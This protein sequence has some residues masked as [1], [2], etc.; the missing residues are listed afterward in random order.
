[1]DATTYINQNLDVEKLLRYYDFQHIT[2]HNDLIRAC[3][4]LH[5]G[6]NPTAFVINVNTGLWYCH[7]GNCGGGDIYTLVEKLEG[8]SKHDFPKTVN[9]VASFFNLDISGLSINNR[10]IDYI[11]DLQN[12]IKAVQSQKHKSFEPFIIKEE[13]KKVIKYRNFSPNTL[14]FFNL[15]Y[16]DYINL[17][18]RQGNPYT[19]YNRLVFPILFDNIQ[20]G[21]S[22][23]RT[24]TNDNP[25]WSHQPVNINFGDLLYNYDVAKTSFEIVICE[26]ITDVWAYHEC[27]IPAVATF[28]SHITDQQYRLLLKTGADLVLSFDG[29]NAGAIATQKAIKLF[30]NKA[31]IKQIYFNTNDDPA[32]IQRKELIKLFEHRKAPTY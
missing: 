32:S 11:K 7:T 3:C 22:L 27:N 20:V 21:V 10:K 13:V 23:R 25:K 31:N 15:G 6:N 17:I 29:D 4:K 12:F 26:G 16:V 8:F 19:L 9:W 28:G 2:I 18:N 14:D 24:K 1:M 5:N 30:K